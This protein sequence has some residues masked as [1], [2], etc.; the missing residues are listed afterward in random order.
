[1]IDPHFAHVAVHQEQRRREAAHERRQA[2]A[3]PA[4][5]DR[6]SARPAWHPAVLV[7]R[8]ALLIGP[9]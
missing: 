8:L 6:R 1:M 2:L 5:E 4:R 9:S 3:A 7:K